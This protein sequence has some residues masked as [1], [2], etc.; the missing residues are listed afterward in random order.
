MGVAPLAGAWIE[1]RLFADELSSF[2]SHPSRVRGLKREVLEATYEKPASHPSRVRGLKLYGQGARRQRADRSHPSR[3]RGLKPQIA[4]D[5]WPWK[6][7]APLAG[8]WIETS[9]RAHCPR[10]SASHPSRVRGLKLSS[11]FLGHET[12]VAPLAGA[13]IETCKSDDPAGS[14]RRTP[15]GCVD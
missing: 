15:R 1:T 7:V 14:P 11:P 10:L 6:T 5:S 13:W 4:A 3:V 9:R 12:L 8:A 2:T